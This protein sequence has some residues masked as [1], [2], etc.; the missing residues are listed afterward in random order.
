VRTTTLPILLVAL[1]GCASVSV[2]A[3]PP[4]GGPPTSQQAPAASPPSFVQDDYAH[5]LALARERRV[6]LFVDAWAPWCHTCLSMHA[7]VFTDRRLASLKDRFVW[8][9]IDTEKRT[10]ADFVARHPQQVWPTLLV[11]DPAT[12]APVLRWLGSATTEQLT[13][14]LEDG[15]RAA[16][17]GAEGADALLARADRLYAE[18]DA[19]RAAALLQDLIAQAPADWPRRARAV[20]SLLFALRFG[21]SP[22]FATCATTAETELATLPRSASW[23]N[24]AALGLS[25]AL[26][27]QLPAAEALEARAREALV[28]PRIE[29]AADDLSSLYNSV[30]NARKAAGDPEGARA[31]AAEWLD[32][33][34]AEAAAAPTPEAR[35]VY[36]YHRMSASL[37][38][39]EPGRAV[40]PLVQSERDFP[41]NYEPPSRLAMVY[42]ALGRHDEA[43]AASDRALALAYGPRKVR[44][45]NDRAAI[46]LAKGD[47]KAA[48]AAFAEALAWWEGLPEAQRSAHERSR[49]T[50]GLAQTAP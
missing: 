46:L 20:E 16:R 42:L 6:P 7:N 35:A 15:E 1:A 8:L 10:N 43:L 50:E 34:E 44:L 9:S 47:R 3:A 12:E 33:L 31:V 26:K 40:A 19:P 24:V 37:L 48:H 30:A 23:A 2:S 22:D 38:L 41:R 11:I 28:P 25:C 29:M 4:V 45:L 39:G 21:D 18:G 36:D 27:G 5:A 32:F 13:A 49:A 17:G 14:L